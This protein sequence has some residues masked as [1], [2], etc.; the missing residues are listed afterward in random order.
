MNGGYLILG[1]S[2]PADKTVQ[3]RC[4]AVS[5]CQHVSFV[6][7]VCGGCGNVA[8]MDETGW[9]CGACGLCPSGIAQGSDWAYVPENYLV[10]NDDV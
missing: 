9:A 2:E 6:W 4:R 10:V 1:E 3:F 8:L 5:G 7:W